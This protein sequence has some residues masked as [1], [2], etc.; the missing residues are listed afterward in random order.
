MSTQ[1]GVI[2]ASGFPERLATYRK[3]RGL[4]QQGLADIAEVSLPQL[5]RYEVGK[6]E[7]T[8]DVIRRLAIALGVST[9]DLIFGSNERDPDDDLRLQFEA[10]KQFTAE[11]KQVAK[12]VIEGLIIK[13][14][15]HKWRKPTA[16]L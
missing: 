9:D 12:S 7:P 15:A 1:L 13:H 14:D 6:S 8:L 4:N 11:E 10:I 5:K 2:M 16:T 3:N